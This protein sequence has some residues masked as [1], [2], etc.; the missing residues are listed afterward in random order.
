MDWII[1]IRGIEA[2]EYM[3]DLDLQ[4]LFEVYEDWD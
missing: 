3:G 2:D 1:G 4:K